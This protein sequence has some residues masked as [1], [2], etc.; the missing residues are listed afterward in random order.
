MSDDPPFPG[1]RILRAVSLLVPAESRLEWLREWSAEVLS[2]WGGDAARS[3]GR[4]AARLRCLGSLEDALR[5]R[6]RR[7]EKGPAGVPQRS[8]VGAAIGVGGAAASDIVGQERYTQTM[9]AFLR[10]RSGLTCL[11]LASLSLGWVLPIAVEPDHYLEHG[12]APRPTA[13]E[14]VALHAEDG[15]HHH[16]RARLELGNTFWQPPCA[17]CAHLGKS[18]ALSAGKLGWRVR[19]DGRSAPLA[20]SLVSS[21]S[22]RRGPEQPRAPP[23]V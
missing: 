19:L 14:R 22:P 16:D 11:L 2:T 15:E 5:L 3:S 1:R 9:S 23:R 13:D 21:S 8:G 12:S 17:L 7:R 6:W 20:E 10:P 18:S 4:F